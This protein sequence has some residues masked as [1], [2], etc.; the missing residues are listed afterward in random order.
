MGGRLVSYLRVDFKRLLSDRKVLV[1]VLLLL[2]IVVIDPITVSRYFSKYP[3][4]RETV[5]QNPFQFWMLINSVS[6]GN[7]LYSTIFW[8]LTVLFTGLIYYEDKSTSMYMNQIIRGGKSQYFFSKFI[9]TGIL[10]FL[11]VLV[12][13][14][15]NV[16]MTYM[17]FP[18]KNNKTVNYD[19][20]VP[21]EGSF[22]YEA[23]I[24]SPINMV[25]I[26]TL[27][28]AL[29]IS[30]FVVFSLCISMLLDF[31]NRY[32]HLVLP[33][34]ILYIINYI[35]D[36]FPE[37]FMYDIRIILQPAAVGAFTDNITWENVVL[38]FGGWML[39]NILLVGA[40][41]YKMRNCYE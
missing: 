13:L 20:L 15:I 21:K 31:K 22:I 2:T 24:S 5:G 33:V 8:F 30:L 35:L 36:S 28:N 26:Y 25:H 10:S 9:S 1:S 18:N 39:V 40:V 23:F 29:A 37:L 4:L 12:T 19:F 14:E 6:W 27:M 7:N 41:F 32:I 3:G 17:L 11:I 34:I 38:V 16:L